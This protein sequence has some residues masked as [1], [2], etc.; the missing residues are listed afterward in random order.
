MEKIQKDQVFY[1][2]LEVIAEKHAPVILI[3]F[4]ID[5]FKVVN[6]VYGHLS[7]DYVIREVSQ[8]IKKQLRTSDIGARYGG[9]EFAVLLPVTFWTENCRVDL[10]FCC[11]VPF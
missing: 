9:K 5:D 1:Q 6:D 11:K 2:S 10:Y 3:L 4:D 7:G 8:I